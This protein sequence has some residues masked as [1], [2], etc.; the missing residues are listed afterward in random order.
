MQPPLR[1]DAWK[2]R[3]LAVF[4]PVFPPKEWPQG[5]L[6]SL[7]ALAHFR[8]L[9]A[10]ETL[11]R[12]GQAC[13]SVPFVIEGSIRVFKRGESGRE[14][15][16]YRIEKGQSCILS[17]GCGSSI[18]AFP[19]SVVVELPTAAAF[20]STE[21]VRRL[22]AESES[23]R[24]Y[25]LD[26]YSRRMSDIMLLVEEVAFRKVDERLAQWLRD[27]DGKDG[28]VA[29][30]HQ[31]LADHVGTSREVVSRIL[32]DWE[33]RSLLELSRGSIRL[34]PDFQKLQQ[35]NAEKKVDIMPHL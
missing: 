18:A 26:Q 5:K 32:K 14:I 11:L 15:T 3:F 34:L 20:L 10:G 9:K 2:E 30:T 33:D 31:E 6:D 16:L 25:V 13:A 21:T 22:L 4:G 35:P 12:E 1:G 29:A 28:I 8:E 7:L 19:A 27:H 24:N 23:F 17:A